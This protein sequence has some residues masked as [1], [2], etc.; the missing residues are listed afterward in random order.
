MTRSIKSLVSRLISACLL[1]A[2]IACAVAA[3][4]ASAALVADYR[5]DDNLNSSVGLAPSLTEV[6]AGGATYATEVVNGA[7]DRVR[8]FPAGAGLSL[9]TTGLIFPGIYT[10][11]M[12]FRLSEASTWE[13]IFDASNASS[14]NGVY[15]K[16]NKL[17]YYDNHAGGDH[18]GTA[19]FAA[20]TYYTVSISRSASGLITIYQDGALQISYNDSSSTGVL[21][22]PDF[23]ARFFVDDN[24]ISGENSPGAVSRI[25]VFDSDIPV[26][27]PDEG[28]NGT[29]TKVNCNFLV[30]TGLNTC[31]AQVADARPGT[32]KR[33]TGTV[34]FSS[35]NGGSFVTGNTCE[36]TPT[37]AS[38][39]VSSC[40]VQDV[41]PSN[42][43]PKVAAAYLGSA[44]HTPSTGTTTFYILGGRVSG[45]GVDLGAEPTLGKKTSG[46]MTVGCV[47][48]YASKR[49]RVSGIT[50]TGCMFAIN[51]AIEQQKNEFV[52][53]PCLGAKTF[54]ELKDCNPRYEQAL[55]EWERLMKE[56]VARLDD[57]VKQRA[58]KWDELKDIVDDY[59]KAAKDVINR[60]GRKSS[61]LAIDPQ[62]AK[63]KQ[64]KSITVGTLNTVVKDGKSKTVRLRLTRQWKPLL[65]LIRRMN[66]AMPG[67]N[68]DVNVS[69]KVQ[70][71]R[72]TKGAK[73]K[74]KVINRVVRYKVIP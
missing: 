58:D 43:L 34:K 30:A 39:N 55:E 53:K 40:S 32:T 51:A 9:P 26:T 64:S 28:K 45:F 47:S 41:S 46:P 24:V 37:T 72:R 29:V 3:S 50:S 5:F 35:G 10:F 1:A 15:V 27:L 66:K 6:G 74:R 48:P 18:F 59:N 19:A 33:P 12:T 31:F 4:S 8:V 14:D 52:G 16:T 61:V 13:R 69:M 62:A 38:R 25:R 7:S 11:E 20:D 70:M 57:Q 60:A 68:L 42:S 63:Q 22:A 65:T 21:L 36:L 2:L 67:L 44:E 49:L 54:A 56:R 17:D 73:P 23:L 71:T